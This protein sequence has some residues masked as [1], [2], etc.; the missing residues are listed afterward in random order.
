[1]KF[2]PLTMPPIQIIW[3]N[4]QNPGH[5]RSS[6]HTS[7]RPNTLYKIDFES[8]N[9]AKCWQPEV[10]CIIKIFVLIYSSTYTFN[11]LVGSS[12][13]ATTLD[14]IGSIYYLDKFN[15]LTRVHRSKLVSY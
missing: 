14:T 11:V 7:L 3:P 8:Q 10:V 13:S 1:M 9:F 6:K 4:I 5:K 2:P 12:R 15:R